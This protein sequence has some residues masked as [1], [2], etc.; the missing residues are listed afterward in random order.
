MATAIGHSDPHAAL[1][2]GTPHRPGFTTAFASFVAAV[3]RSA[4]RARAQ[5]QL[6][7]LDDRTLRDIGVDRTE[8]TSV[9]HYGRNDETRRRR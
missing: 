6:L 9:V 3:R 4:E 2:H 8:I 1:N 5:Q 7:E